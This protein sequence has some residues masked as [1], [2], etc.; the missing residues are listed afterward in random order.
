M[1]YESVRKIAFDLSQLASMMLSTGK[2]QEELQKERFTYRTKQM[3]EDAQLVYPVKTLQIKE[4]RKL[5]RIS[6]VYIGQSEALPTQVKIGWSDNLRQRAQSLSH[7]YDHKPFHII[8]YFKTDDPVKLEQGLHAHFDPWRI[9]GEWFYSLPVFEWLN[10][11]I[12]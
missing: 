11:V 8:A 3:L 2:T 5:K 7:Q 4:G 6:G 10:E 9:G 1:D 12:S